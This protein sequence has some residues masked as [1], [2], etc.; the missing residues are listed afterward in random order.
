[1]VT[2]NG[3]SQRSVYGGRTLSLPP[4]LCAL[5]VGASWCLCQVLGCAEGGDLAASCV[6]ASCSEPS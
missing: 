4:D 3:W 6:L 2:G 1:M 5:L